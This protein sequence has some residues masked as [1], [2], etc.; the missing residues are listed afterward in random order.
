MSNP[1]VTVLMITCR[2]DAAFIEHPDWHVLGKVVED[3][4]AQTFR[5][6]ELVIVDGLKLHYARDADVLRKAKFPFKHIAPKENLWTRNKK[7]CISNYRNTGL[8]AARGE[9]VVNIDDVNYLPPVYLSLFWKAYKEHHICLTATWP[10][11]GDQVFGYGSYPL[12]MALDLNG[13]DEAYDGGMYL[14]DI[15]WGCRLFDYGL[16]M[17]F[18][19]IPGFRQFAQSGHHPDVVDKD[20]PNC[21]CCNAAWQTN[22]VWRTI[23]KANTPDLW[24]ERALNRLLGPCYYM[25]RDGDKYMCM[26]WGGTTICEYTKEHHLNADGKSFALERDELA[27]KIFEEPP[28]RDLIKER[29]EQS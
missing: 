5:D 6:F 9:L 12:S 20:H 11:N 8:A 2:P 28:V 16:K 18:A 3:L 26:H 14:E 22:Q 21:K 7:T 13:Y 23:S 10:H 1:K 19:Y 17:H 29:E 15:D 25:K 24:P 27:A 4:N